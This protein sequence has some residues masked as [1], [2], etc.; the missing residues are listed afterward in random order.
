MLQ[1]SEEGYISQEKECFWMYLHGNEVFGAMSTPSSPVFMMLYYVYPCWH[2]F[3]SV[4]SKA[5]I[6]HLNLND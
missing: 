6:Q 1:K 5:T 3:L 2:V 4:G